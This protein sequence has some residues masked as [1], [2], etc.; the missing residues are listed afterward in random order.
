MPHTPPDPRRPL[1]LAQG[2]YFAA[3][4]VWPLL[5]MRSFLAV[6][7]RKRDLWLVQTVGALIAVV[8]ASLLVAGRRGRVGPETVA[9]GA[10]SA[11]ALGA[12]D[13]VFVAQRRIPAVYLLDAVAEAGIVAAWALAERAR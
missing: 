3:T 10:G 5:H 11:A 9:L 4:G 8:G 7:G 12:V 13:V 6:T 1:A 2:V